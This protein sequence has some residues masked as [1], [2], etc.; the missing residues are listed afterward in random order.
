MAEV[1]AG[2]TGVLKI[3]PAKSAMGK[4]YPCMASLTLALLYSGEVIPSSA[5]QYA[6]AAEMYSVRNRIQPIMTTKKA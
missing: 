2:H 5:V 6:Y 3:K 1:R 4:K